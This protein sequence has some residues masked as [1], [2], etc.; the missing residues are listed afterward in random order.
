MNKY[1]KIPSTNKTFCK[2]VITHLEISSCLYQRSRLP[3]ADIL[4]TVTVSSA[5]R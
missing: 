3:T 4:A 2:D 5:S 1:F